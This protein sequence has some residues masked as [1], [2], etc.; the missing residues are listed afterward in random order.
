LPHKGKSLRLKKE[1]YGSSRDAISSTTFNLWSTTM[2]DKFESQSSESYPTQ[3]KYPFLQ[4]VGKEGSLTLGQ[5]FPWMI[6]AL[7]S[8]AMGSQGSRSAL[9][10]FGCGT[11]L[12]LTFGRLRKLVLKARK[13]HEGAPDG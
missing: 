2:P 11:V 4:W 6:V 10:A 13:R 7:A 5:S 1:S 12:T 9:I 3:R 8:I